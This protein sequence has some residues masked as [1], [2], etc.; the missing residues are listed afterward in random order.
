MYLKLY[1]NSGL[2]IPIWNSTGKEDES[3][4]NVLTAIGKRLF[5]TGDEAVARAALEV[6]VEVATGYPGNRAQKPLLLLFRLLS[7]ME[8]LWN[9]V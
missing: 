1:V 6:G 3:L 9:G 4:V 2:C 8:W 7:N 5:L